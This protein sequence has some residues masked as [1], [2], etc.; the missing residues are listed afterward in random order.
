MKAQRKYANNIGT[1]KGTQTPSNCA[2]WTVA[3]LPQM[4]ETTFVQRLG[5]SLYLHQRW[6]SRGLEPFVDQR[7]TQNLRHAGC[8]LLLPQPASAA[9]YPGEIDNL[10]STP[11]SG[12][13]AKTDYALNQGVQY[14]PVPKPAL[15]GI[16]QDVHLA[17]LDR[18][19]AKNVTDGLSQTYLVGERAML[20]PFYESIKFPESQG[21][22]FVGLDGNRAA[23]YPPVRDP[24][25]TT[26]PTGGYRY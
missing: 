22:I 6:H 16:A 19:S 18:V 24:N 7:T 15:P 20:Q 3:I 11:G 23:D 5:E 1:G 9:A 12:L 2:P 10:T 14:P 21:S 4:Q 26:W 8:L 17:G 25:S 13:V